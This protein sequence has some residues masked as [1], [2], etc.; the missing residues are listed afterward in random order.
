[1]NPLEPIFT[2]SGRPIPPPDVYALLTR[3]YGDTPFKAS[4]GR[5]SRLASIPANEITDIVRHLEKQGVDLN[6]Q[7]QRLPKILDAHLDNI[8]EDA[9]VPPSDSRMP[10][11]WL[12]LLASEDDQPGS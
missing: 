7:P 1:M 9:S 8:L 4:D 3:I 2:E 10:N 5:P 11:W 6:A 12:R